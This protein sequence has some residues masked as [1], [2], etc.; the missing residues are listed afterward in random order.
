MP[1]PSRM[2][3]DPT[4]RAVRRRP[5]SHREEVERALAE[6]RA[7]RVAIPARTSSEMIEAILGEL[8]RQLDPLLVGSKLRELSGEELDRMIRISS[9]TIAIHRQLSDPS[10]ADVGDV[11]TSQLER[12]AG[13]KR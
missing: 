9:A 1:H 13:K 4:A 10:G 7:A 6:Q 5:A 2:V 3:D 11:P 8:N 12:I